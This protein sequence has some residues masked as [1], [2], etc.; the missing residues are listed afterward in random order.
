MALGSIAGGIASAG[1]SKLLS[2]AF[3]GGGGS[4]GQ[5][6]AFRPIGIK[7]GGLSVKPKAGKIKANA[8]PERE[9]LVSSL[10]SLFPEQAQEIAGLRARVTPGFGELT[11]SRLQEVES[12]RQRAIG[13]LSENLQRR[14]VLGSS[15]AQD[16]LARAESQ[17]GREAQ[18]ARAQSFLEELDLTNQLIGQEYNAR[19]GEFQT[20]LDELNLQADLATQLA[21]GATSTLAAN[22]R[23]QAQL[24]AQAAA[25]RG[26]FF[27]Q[28]V[29]GPIS[30]AVG[31]GIED[32]L[33]GDEEE[34]GP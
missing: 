1:T 29:I 25:A 2:S 34:P 8:T 24:S 12:A 21:S 27:G 13:N 4:G 18:R 22:A 26:R 32:I 28:E 20:Y 30:D 3:G 16:A 6:S 31:S 15:F 9:R 5:L 7:A 23:L 11:Q 19:R 33:T 14:R 17:F 10:A